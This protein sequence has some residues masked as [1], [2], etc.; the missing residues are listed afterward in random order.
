MKLVGLAVERLRSELRELGDEG[1]VFA[2]A[3]ETVLLGDLMATV[4]AEEV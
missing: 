2:D 4:F 3:V 1:S